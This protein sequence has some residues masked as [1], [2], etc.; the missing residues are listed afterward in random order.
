MNSL[1]NRLNVGLLLTFLINKKIQN[2]DYRQKKYAS[3]KK[4]TA[5]RKLHED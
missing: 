5:D 4:N 2:E 1:F 3:K